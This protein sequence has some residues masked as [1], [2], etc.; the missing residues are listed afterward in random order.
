MNILVTGGS[1]GLG[2]TTVEL[3]AKADEKKHNIWFTYNS[4]KSEALALEVAYSNVN[5]IEADFINS[6]SIDKVLDLMGAMDLDVLVNNAYVGIPQSAHFHKITAEDFL[7]GFKNNILPTIR[8]SQKAILTFKKKKFGKIIN[9]LT[10]AIM[11]LPPI[12]Y[13]IYTANKAYLQQLSKVWNKEYAAYNI[14]SNCILPEYMCTE[15]SDVDERILE[16]MRLN[17]PLKKLLSPQEVADVILFLINAPQYINGVS[18]PVN[19]AQVVN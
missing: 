14:T 9:I 7:S 19:S 1:T 13:S 15:F 11:G 16:Q 4:H 12:G 3:L 5:A 10:A 6:E 2:K 8:I 17:H 18:I